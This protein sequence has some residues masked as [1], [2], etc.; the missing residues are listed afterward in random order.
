MK[1]PKECP[2]FE[3]IADGTIY[4]CVDVSRGRLVLRVRHPDWFD[5]GFGCAFQTSPARIR[6]VTEPV[7]E[8]A[9]AMLQ[10]AKAGGK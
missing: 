4:E 10:I 6:G 3:R 8:I 9:R 2:V 7:T 5:D 1:Y